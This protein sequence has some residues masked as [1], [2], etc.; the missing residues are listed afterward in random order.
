MA[1]QPDHEVYEAMMTAGHNKTFVSSLNRFYA[2][3]VLR[4]PLS[5]VSVCAVPCL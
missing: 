5:V 3:Q 4:C 1:I 2:E